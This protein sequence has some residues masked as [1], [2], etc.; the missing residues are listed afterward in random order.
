MR[1]L[2]SQLKPMLMFSNDEEL[3]FV[4]DILQKALLQ[5]AESQIIIDLPCLL[6]R[7]GN[8]KRKQMV[9]DILKMWSV[10]GE[11]NVTGALPGFVVEDV[12]QTPFC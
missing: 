2:C 10:V 9:D 12:S 11:H 7:Q 5:T 6:K 4:K 8:N 1:N 3:T